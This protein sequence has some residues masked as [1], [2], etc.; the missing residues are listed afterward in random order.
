MIESDNLILSSST[1][2]VHAFLLPSLSIFF[3]E[4]SSFII[5]VAV[6]ALMI[7][8]FQPTS[9]ETSLTVLF[10]TIFSTT[11]GDHR[12]DIV[13]HLSAQIT[14]E[15]VCRLSLGSNDVLA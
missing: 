12:T 5:L 13:S 6:N 7:S 11:W 4:I 2:V 9:C 10:V 15:N 3:H 1:M 14:V 8:C